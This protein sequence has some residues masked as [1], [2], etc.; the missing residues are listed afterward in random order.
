MTALKLKKFNTKHATQLTK[1]VIKIIALCDKL[2]AFNSS[3]KV[4]KKKK[5]NSK[6]LKT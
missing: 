2:I 3:V 5:I 4:K 1:D 6:D